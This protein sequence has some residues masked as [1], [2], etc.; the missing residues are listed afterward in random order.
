MGPKGLYQ[1]KSTRSYGSGNPAG[2]LSY[3]VDIPGKCICLRDKKRKLCFWIV[4][5]IGPN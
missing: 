5:P 1:G 4:A 2:F 3:Q